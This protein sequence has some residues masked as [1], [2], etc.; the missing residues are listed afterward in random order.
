[1]FLTV[2]LKVKWVNVFRYMD[3]DAQNAIL[4]YPNYPHNFFEYIA[5]N[6]FMQD[7][8]LLSALLDKKKPLQI[9]LGLKQAKKQKGKNFFLTCSRKYPKSDKEFNYQ[10]AFEQA[11]VELSKQNRIMPSMDELLLW[12]NKILMHEFLEEKEI[13]TPKT[14]YYPFYNNEIKPGLK[15]PI[16]LKLAH[17]AGGTGII[18]FDTIDKCRT[19]LEKN[20]PEAFLLQEWMDIKRDLRMVFINNKLELHYMRINQ[21]DSW[22]A[23]ST[24]NVAEVDFDFIP[25]GCLEYMTKIDRKIG[26]KACAYDIAWN[27]DNYNLEPFVLEISPSF[28]P[29]PKPPKRFENRPYNHYYPR[30]FIRQPYFRRLP[31][32]YFKIHRL[33]VDSINTNSN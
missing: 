24:F 8:A 26:L 14:H 19:Y 12:E 4:I 23:N 27:D 30:I 20:K 25:E 6:D 22:K 1:M 32:M 13:R 17:S 29:N 3:N 11:L 21:D 18:K 7:M 5:G 31:E 33:R 10:E 2:L 16:I 28:L 15:Y 9:C